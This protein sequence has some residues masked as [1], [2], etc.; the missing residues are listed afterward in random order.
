[1]CKLQTI[2]PQASFAYKF[3]EYEENVWF[4]N[5]A[6]YMEDSDYV[7]GNDKD[8]VAHWSIDKL[9]EFLLN[10]VIVFG[11][12]DSYNYDL[13]ESK[14]KLFISDNKLKVIENYTG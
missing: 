1:M 8:S 10:G 6:A 5:N 9:K 13:C 2:I 14:L 4:R 3:P 12:R 11:S 7:I